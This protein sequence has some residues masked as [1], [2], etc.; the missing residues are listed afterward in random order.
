MN[1][2]DPDPVPESAQRAARFHHERLDVYGAA[3]KFVVMTEELL[4]ALPR[5]R[6]HLAG[7]LRRAATSIVLNIAEGA[8]E[9]SRQSKR[10]FYRMAAR[11]ATEC[12]ANLDIMEATRL[13]E[14][15]K[16]GAGRD[17]LVRIVAMLT[18]LAMPRDRR[19]GSGTGTGSG[20]GS[21][22]GTGTGS[23]SGTGLGQ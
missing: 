9:F 15:E 10:H 23:G 14:A 19:P 21:G 8:G 2:P 20:T 11:S 17:L 1:V 12:A 16:L 7:Q 4:K 22:S 3:L 18:R 13:V 5:G 6:A